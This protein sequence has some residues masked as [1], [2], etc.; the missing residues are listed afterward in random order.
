MI[1]DSL[2]LSF[3][4]TEGEVGNV[5]TLDF[6]VEAGGVLQKPKFAVIDAAKPTPNLWRE[7]QKAEDAI[8]EKAI[9][10]LALELV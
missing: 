4:V 7:Q 10:A 2:T 1:T 3:L 9:L 5:I 8:L 6:F